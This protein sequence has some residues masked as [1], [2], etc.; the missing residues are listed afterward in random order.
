MGIDLD[1]ADYETI[2]KHSGYCIG[3]NSEIVLI[4]N[5]EIEII[6][7][8]EKDFNK[9]EGIL[10]KYS[11]NKN[12]SLLEISNIMEKINNIIDFDAEV[13]FGTEIDV[14]MNI[15][16]CKFHILITGLKER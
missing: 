13:I 11:I 16:E 5:L 7:R 10:I 12:Q 9:A 15:E 4:N 1:Y 6:Q 8:F 2:N 14:D 3:F